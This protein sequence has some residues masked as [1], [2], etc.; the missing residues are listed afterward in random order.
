MHDGFFFLYRYCT[1]TY[2]ASHLLIGNIRL[3]LAFC[4]LFSQGGLSSDIEQLRTCHRCHRIFPVLSELFN[5]ICEDDDK[6]KTQFNSSKSDQS[7]SSLLEQ[8]SSTSSPKSFKLSRHTPFNKSPIISSRLTSPLSRTNSPTSINEPEYI[9]TYKRPLYHLNEREHA[10]NA[11][12][13]LRTPPRSSASIRVY[14]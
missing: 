5:H 10:S 12:I 1:R 8:I 2:A 11:Y 9:P 3:R 6:E 7:T 13:S 4:F 14:S